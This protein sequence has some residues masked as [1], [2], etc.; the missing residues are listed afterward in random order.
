MRAA[1]FISSE[2][3]RAVTGE[4][5]WSSPNK[6]TCWDLGRLDGEQTISVLMQELRSEIWTVTASRLGQ[7]VSEAARLVLLR[8][9]VW[10]FTNSVRGET[11]TNRRQ[12]VGRPRLIY[13]VWTEPTDGVLRHR[14]HETLMMVMGSLVSLRKRFTFKKHF[15]LTAS[16]SLSLSR[17]ACFSFLSVRV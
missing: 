10:E 15:D 6:D 5:I 11:N 12:G 7:N 14:S 8:S 1:K 13:P 9:A 3:L 2:T 17:C 16:L 4:A